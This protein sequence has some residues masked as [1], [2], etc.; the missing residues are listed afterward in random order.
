MIV[1]K[2]SAISPGSNTDTLFFLEF[3]GGFGKP[4]HIPTSLTLFE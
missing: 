4:L 3:S 2:M 1:D